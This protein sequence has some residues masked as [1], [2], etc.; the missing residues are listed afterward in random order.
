[1]Q[2]VRQVLTDAPPMIPVPTELQHRRVEVI[3]RPLPEKAEESRPIATA[4]AVIDQIRDLVAGCE[5]VELGEFQLD[6]TGFKFDREEAN[7]R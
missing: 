3:F 1:M 6:L 4:S 2:L 5:P 7:A